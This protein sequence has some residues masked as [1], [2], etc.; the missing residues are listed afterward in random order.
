MLLIV[1]WVFLLEWLIYLQ[2][3][4]VYDSPVYIKTNHYTGKCH[5]AQNGTFT[6]KCLTFTLDAGE[7]RAEEEV[8]QLENRGWD[9][10]LWTVTSIAWLSSRN[11]VHCHSARA[12]QILRHNTEGFAWR[13]TQSSEFTDS[14]TWSPADFPT[15]WR[16]F[17][18]LSSSGR[19]RQHP[20][21]W[22]SGRHWK[23]LC[24]NAGVLSHSSS[25]PYG[26]TP[27]CCEYR[28]RLNTFLNSLDIL[29]LYVICCEYVKLWMS[30]CY[31]S[32]KIVHWLW[33]ILNTSLSK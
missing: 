19:S 15:A 9:G 33:L 32:S 25:R 10:M 23:I 24:G 11:F 31:L 6:P 22:G 14:E 16:F 17:V 26:F 27:T 5:E 29:K 7:N 2:N 12:Q 3:P 13:F 8:T 28:F 21:A 18:A 4:T 30:N 20:P 1:C